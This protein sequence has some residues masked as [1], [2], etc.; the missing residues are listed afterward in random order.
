[1]SVVCLRSHHG[2]VVLHAARIL[3]LGQRVQVHGRL[4]EAGFVAVVCSMLLEGLAVLSNAHHVRSRAAT[5]TAWDDSLE[6]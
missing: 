5:A 4:G 6:C 2:R 1:L 3:G